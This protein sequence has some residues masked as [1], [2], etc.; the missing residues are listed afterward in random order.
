[1]A[2]RLIDKLRV[3]SLFS[4]GGAY[5]LGLEWAG[6]FETVGLV[7][8]DPYCQ[9]LLAERFPGVPVFG[10]VREFDPAPFSGKIDLMVGGFPCQDISTAGRGAG[11][12]G[13]RSSL[14]A[15]YARCICMA[16]PRYA[17]VENVREITNRGLG[18]VLGS[19]AF[20]GYDAEW[21]CISAVSLGSIYR[22][23]EADPE[24]EIRFH[25][26][27]RIITL[28]TLPDTDRERIWLESE[29]KFG[30][31]GSPFITDYGQKEDVADT[32]LLGCESEAED[33]H[34][35]ESD[36]SGKGAV[37]ADTD[38]GRRKGEGVSVCPRGPFEKDSLSSRSRE[39]D[40]M[41]DS[42]REPGEEGAEVLGELPGLLEDEQASDNAE[43]SDQARNEGFLKGVGQADA[44][45]LDA[46]VGGPSAGEIFGSGPEEAELRGGKGDGQAITHSAG[47]EG[48][49][50][51]LQLREDG[52]K[53]SAH[54]QDCDGILEKARRVGSLA[55]FRE[56]TYECWAA[57]PCVR[58][59]PARTPTYMDEI[60]LI[61][62]ANPPQLFQYLGELIL[63][64]ERMIAQFM[65]KE[66]NNENSNLA[67]RAGQ[68]SSK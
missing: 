24:G 36:P 1:M 47:L 39:G 28:A 32:D 11:I 44:H 18:V 67:N 52:P 34:R 51:E 49:G 7:E 37:L 33:A 26:R 29:R 68:M 42:R 56:R 55:K 21:D 4:G 61:G 64:R 23:L 3:L 31:K 41:E 2:V 65:I 62:N 8:I 12:E 66:D 46:Y 13:E 38:V 25:H 16:R 6:G 22:D 5:D 48:Y 59:I 60:R 57:E 9:A 50:A 20:G 43:R 15:E 10:D 40:S 17:V 58:C 14:W 54:G 35:R 19:L 63:E 27:N 30:S 45:K 53:I